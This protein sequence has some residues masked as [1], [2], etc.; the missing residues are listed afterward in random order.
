MKKI[1]AFLL[2]IIGTMGYGQEFVLDYLDGIVDMREGT[3]WIEIDLGDELFDDSVIRLSDDT[4]AEISGKGMRLTLTEP[5]V[6]S[7][8]DLLDSNKRVASWGI[9]SVLGSK[10]GALTGESKQGKTAVMGVRAAAADSGPELN[11]MDEGEE[12]L[13]EGKLLL[14]SGDYEEAVEIFE[15]GYDFADIDEEQQF[16]F[17][18]G[19]AYA[20]QG[21]NAQAMKYLARVEAEIYAPYFADLVLLKGQ[22]LVQSL[23]FQAAIELFDLY[24][25]S[26]SS[27]RLSG[28]DLP[29]GQHK[30]AILFLSAIGRQGLDDEAEAFTLLKAARD[31]DPASEIGRAAAERLNQQ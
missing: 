30:Q 3:S 23:S 13:A 2:F 22:L 26:L 21:R 6:Y 17:H 27:G 12:L 19:Y 9:G 16:L 31:L 25:T 5:G 15:E 18:I 11:W 7:I 4:M 1:V 14:Q 29:G 28:G 10:L 24:L 8:A 20:L